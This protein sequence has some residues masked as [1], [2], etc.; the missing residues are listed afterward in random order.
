MNSR[1]AQLDVEI[2]VPSAGTNQ[3]RSEEGAP[4]LVILLSYLRPAH[5]HLGT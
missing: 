5:S 1:R 4:F 3:S 2:G